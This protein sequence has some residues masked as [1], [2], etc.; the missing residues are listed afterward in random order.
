MAAI[1][2]GLDCSHPDIEEFLHI[3]ETN[4]KLEHMNISI[5]FTDE[6]MQAVR[7]GK[8]YTCSFFVPE[9]GETIKKELMLKNFQKIL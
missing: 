3:K 9:T 4:H 7:D 2:I 1:M 6:F 5:L 8:N